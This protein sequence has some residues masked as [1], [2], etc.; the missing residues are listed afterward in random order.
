[1][2]PSRSPQADTG[3]ALI[4]A[5]AVDIIGGTIQ[6]F[7]SGRTKKDKKMKINHVPA[8]TAAFLLF[9]AACPVAGLAQQSMV[10]GYATASVTNEEVVA[11]AD[12]AVKAQED[13]MQQKKDVEPA[14]L[15]L[16]AILGAEQQV[17]AGMNYRLRLRV[18]LNGNEKTADVVVWWQAWRKPDPYELTSW[19][20]N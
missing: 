13:A 10:G 1:M 6:L 14:K 5:F 2:K 7:Y 11:A 19:N 18:K 16:V 20:W 8:W 9:T 4:S 17:V 15:E 12:Y 3:C